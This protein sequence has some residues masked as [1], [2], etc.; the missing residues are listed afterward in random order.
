M[1][2]GYRLA[3]TGI[4]LLAAAALLAAEAPRAW[5][6]ADPAGAGHSVLSFIHSGSSARLGIGSREFCVPGIW[7]V[8][9]FSVVRSI[10]GKLIVTAGTGSSRV[11][12]RPLGSCSSVHTLSEWRPWYSIAP[13]MAMSPP[14]PMRM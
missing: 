11:V 4:A 6:I 8:G 9:P 1:T 13:G 3:M 7:R 2:G 10:I 12:M 5:R 14:A